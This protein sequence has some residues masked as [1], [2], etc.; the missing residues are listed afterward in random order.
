MYN[1]IFILRTWYSEKI[2][3]LTVEYCPG[4]MD[5]CV[6]PVRPNCEDRTI[7]CLDD[8]P[9]YDDMNQKNLTGNDTLHERSLGAKYEYSCKNAGNY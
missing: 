7:L 2:S 9:L 3:D 1:F 8:L 5:E 6:N 4:G